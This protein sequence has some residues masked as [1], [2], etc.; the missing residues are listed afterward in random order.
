MDHFT[1][2]SRGFSVHNDAIL[3]MRFDT[4]QGVTAEQLINTES[5]ESLSSI[6]QRYADFTPVKADELATAIAKTRKENPIH[7]TSDLRDIL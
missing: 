7:T 1:D 4:T 2:G 6:F 3:D 5:I